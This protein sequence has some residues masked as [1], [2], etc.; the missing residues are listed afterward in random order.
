MN[1]DDKV[2]IKDPTGETTTVGIRNNVSLVTGV[3]TSAPT[4]SAGTEET[5][6]TQAADV[7]AEAETPVETETE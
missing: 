4:P 3:D 6:V 5:P 7:P 2:D 1:D